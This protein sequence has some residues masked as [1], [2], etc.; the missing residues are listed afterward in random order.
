MPEEWW[1]PVV[2]HWVETI[3]AHPG[4]GQVTVEIAK[5]KV[6]FVRWGASL[7]APAPTGGEGLL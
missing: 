5:G 3:Q 7:K 6:E 1:Y 2:H 4:Y